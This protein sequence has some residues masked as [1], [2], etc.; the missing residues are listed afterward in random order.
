MTNFWRSWLRF[1]YAALITTKGAS[2]YD[3][4]LLPR[5]NP[6]RGMNVFMPQEA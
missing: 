5:H 1:D 6:E 4:A 3:G 2:F